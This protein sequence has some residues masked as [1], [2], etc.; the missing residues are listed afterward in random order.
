MQ[1]ILTGKIIPYVRMTQ[2]GKW[3]DERAQEYLSNKD[4]LA[5]QFRRQ[6]P[7]MLPEQKPLLMVAIIETPTPHK[8][9]LDN[10]CKAIL[11]AAQGIVFRNDCWIDM[12][13]IQRKRAKEYKAQVQI[14]ELK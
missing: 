7:E 2:R 10:I 8:G 13:S 3:V 11:D 4:E 9:D 12:I 1:F 5:R 6:C 14:E